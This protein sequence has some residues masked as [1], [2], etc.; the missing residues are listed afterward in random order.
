MP[1]RRKVRNPLGLA[2]MSYLL[3]RPMHP[4]ELSRTL[5]E[6]GDDRSI[7]FNHGSL[8]MVVGQ[9]ERAGFIAA[10]VHAIAVRLCGQETRRRQS[11]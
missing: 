4:Y 6:H 2:V 11:G 10:R 5:R 8:Y 1:S 3:Q 9:L 7:R